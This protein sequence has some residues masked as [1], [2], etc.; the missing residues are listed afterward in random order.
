MVNFAKPIYMYFHG[1]P[2]RTVVPHAGPY[3]ITFHAS[4]LV[5]AASPL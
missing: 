4:E 1:V 5:P 2:L 3:E